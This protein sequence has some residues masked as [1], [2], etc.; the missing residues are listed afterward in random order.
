MLDEFGRAH[1]AATTSTVSGS[2]SRPLA[3][4]ANFLRE[5]RREQQVLPLGRQQREHAADVADETHVEHAIGLVEHEVANAAQVDVALVGVIEQPAGRRDDDVGALAQ[6]V[7]LRPRADAAENQQR[8]LLE[9]TTE[10]DEGLLHLRREFARRHEHEAA[11]GA[12][13][14]RVRLDCREHLQQRQRERGRLAGAR[15]GG[16]KQVATFEHRRDAA[17][18]DRGGFRVAEFCYGAHEFGREAEGIK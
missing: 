4:A 8:A 11:R 13:A 5:R 17:G 1:C 6:C 18:L 9:V 2:C 7:D 16:G 10:I 3:S 15:L 12:R 14:T